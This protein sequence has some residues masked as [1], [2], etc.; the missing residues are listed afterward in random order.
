MSKHGNITMEP[1]EENH[2]QHD[3]AHNAEATEVK[4]SPLQ[5][6]IK[7]QQEGGQS[8]L[9]HILTP[10]IFFHNIS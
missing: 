5:V 2:S 7:V 8:L 1:E 3:E 4:L 6:L 9:P 10:S